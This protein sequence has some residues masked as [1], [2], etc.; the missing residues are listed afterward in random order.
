[1]TVYSQDHRGEEN[2]VKQLQTKLREKEEQVRKQME[3]NLK[4]LTTM[5][6]E[7]LQ[8][9]NVCTVYFILYSVVYGRK[10]MLYVITISKTECFI[11]VIYQSVVLYITLNIVI[12]EIRSR[13][14]LLY[15]CFQYFGNLKFYI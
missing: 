3:A 4:E 1:V 5:Q 7:I 8:Q 6:E 9:M 14:T 12:L 15:S 2:A 10:C 11:R 13:N